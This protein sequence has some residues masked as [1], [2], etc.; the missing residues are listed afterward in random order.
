MRARWVVGVALFAGGCGGAFEAAPSGSDASTSND[1]SLDAP[2]S[3]A[4]GAEGGGVTEGGT[5]DGGG[6]DDGGGQ[7]DGGTDGG[8]ASPDAGRDAAEDS[9]PEAGMDA[10]KDSGPEA[11]KDAGPEAGKDAGTVE[12][13]DGGSWSTV[14]PANAPAPATTCQVSGLQCE[15]PQAMYGKAEYDI[16]CDTV[17]E[18]SNGIWTTTSF[19]GAC[20]PDGANSAECPTSLAGITSGGTCSDKQLR[21]EY[22]KGVCTCAV[23]IGGVELLDAGATWTCDPGAGCPMPRPRLGSACG[24]STTMNSSCIY[25]TCSYAE[26]CENDVWQAQG[27]ACGVGVGVGSP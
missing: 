6:G 23:N 7:V 25:E 8:D 2:M 3:D 5:V 14:C 21:C 17:V 4:Q 18:C 11:G 20:D 22:P 10:A 26:T 24:G 19:G 1:S 12:G 15:Y 27:A 9:G 13:G 16:S